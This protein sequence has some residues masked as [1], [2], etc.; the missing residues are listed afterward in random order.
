MTSIAAY[1]A[2]WRREQ[3]Q[4]PKRTA[5]APAARRG[6]PLLAAARWLAVAGLLAYS[7]HSLLG[8]CGHGLDG[9]FENWVFN[10]LLCAGATMCLAR[11]VCSPLERPAW[12]ALGVGLGCW[13]LGEI[14]YTIDPGQ[15][16][17]GSFPT[18]SDVLWLTFYPASFIALGVLVRARA[19]DFYPSLWLDGAVGA[20]ALAALACEFILPPIV[21]GTGGSLSSVVGD[22][23]YPLGDLLLVCFALGVL[24]VTGW[25]PGRVLTMVAVGLALGAVADGLSLYWSATGHAGSGIFDPLWPASAVVLGWA[26]WQ[27]TRPAAVVALHGRRLLVFPMCF[28]LAAL[29]LLAL[30]EARPLHD[31]AYVLAVLTI[32]GAVAR[33]GM[34]FTENLRLVDRSRHEALTDP[35]TGL[36]NRRGLLLALEDVLQSASKR[37]PWV[38]LLF[39]LNGF[40]RYN[41]TFGHPVGDALLA[42]LGAKLADAVAPDG[43]AYRLGGDEF[44]VLARLG[45]WPVEAVSAA[46]TAAL[47]EQGQG[48][49]ITT[50]HGRILLPAEAQDSS[51]ALQL[52]DE[53]LYADKRSRR[54][55]TPEQLRDVLLQ[56]MA[57]RAPDLP[58]HLSEVALMARAVG[59]QM[60]LV[61]ED[62]E[63]LVRAAELHDVGKVAVPDVILQKQSALDASERVIIE[64]HCE[65]GERI[66]AAA[67]AMGPVAR[68]VRASHERFDGAGYPDRRVGE[69]IPLGARIIAVCD[70]FHAMTNNRPYRSGMG[71]VDAFSRLRKDAGSQ[72]DPEVVDAFGAILAAGEAC[73]PAPAP[74]SAMERPA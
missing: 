56:V 62:L 46:A 22:L 37:S 53:R 4:A 57:E 32:A 64:R 38:L 70:A 47:S 33:M 36:G 25:R 72:F 30:Q 65:V 34:T 44:C 71:V 68:L 42:R 59:R 69:D 13:A 54:S 45:R 31:G 12:A 52:A 11:A 26:A 73:V 9:F 7:A 39:D 2:Q 41:D 17:T 74:G 10:A 55:D 50:A 14:L 49:E 21:A 58:E 18:T 66:L 28:V 67:P 15:V 24:A 23:V 60:G 20:T 8:A 5:F 63:V 29:G 19:R 3:R 51:T 1:T 27:P 40:K 16:T 48:F 35:L 61:G 43:R 6:R